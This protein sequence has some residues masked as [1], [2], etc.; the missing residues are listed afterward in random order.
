ML[1]LIIEHIESYSESPVPLSCRVLSMFA[2]SGF[3]VEIL[4]SFVQGDS[5]CLISFFC[6]WTSHF[7]SIIFLGGAYCLFS[8]IC[9]WHLC[10]T[11]GGCQY[12]CLLTTES[13][14]QLIYMV[15]LMLLPCLFS[16]LWLCKITLNLNYNPLSVTLFA[17]AC[18]G[19]SGYFVV[20]YEI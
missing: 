2:S 8:T 14:V 6:M 5:M 20:P 17:Q 7:S 19:Y 3:R 12:V 1:A 16:L 9:F 13:S 4:D 11:P 18:C 15:I 10:L